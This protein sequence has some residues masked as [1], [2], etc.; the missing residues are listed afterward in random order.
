M[1]GGRIRSSL[2]GVRR[3]KK[4]SV[5]QCGG[6]GGGGQDDGRGRPAGVRGGDVGPERRRRGERRRIAGGEKTE[7]VG[8]E[9]GWQGNAAG[10]GAGRGRSKRGGAGEGGGDGGGIIDDALNDRA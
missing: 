10:G 9:R 2:L 7:G 6:E 8:L 5:R 3:A 4:F 1:L